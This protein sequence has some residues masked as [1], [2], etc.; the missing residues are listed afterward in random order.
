M[1]HPPLHSGSMESGE[2]EC[3]DNASDDG[4]S[5]GETE[6]SVGSASEAASD[7]VYVLIVLSF[8]YLLSKP[9]FTGEELIYV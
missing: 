6:Y 7:R 5:V 4:C 2:T 8:L 9:L 1:F 3:E